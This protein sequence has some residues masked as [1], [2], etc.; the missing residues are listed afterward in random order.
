MPADIDI[1]TPEKS[2]IDLSNNASGDFGLNDYTLSF[3][4]DD[5]ILVKYVDLNADDGDLIKRGSLYIKA[6]TVRSAWR[7][8]EVILAGPNVKYV[9]KGDIVIFPNDKGVTVANIDIEGYGL[10]KQGMFLNEQRIFGICK[11]KQTDVNG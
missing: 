8:A 4:F 6:G 5:I 3:I 9:K 2:L 10:L 1:L 7:K 11:P